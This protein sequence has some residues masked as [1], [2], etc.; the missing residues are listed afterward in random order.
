MRVQDVKTGEVFE[1]ARDLA[2]RMM[3]DGEVIP[4]VTPPPIERAVAP[5]SE[6]R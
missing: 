3:K 6:L 5:Q 4:V 2:L 1:V